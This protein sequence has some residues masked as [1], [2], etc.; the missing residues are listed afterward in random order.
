MCILLLLNVFLLISVLSDG[1]ES[2]RGASET[3]QAVKALLAE[4]GFTV[5]DGAVRVERAPVACTLTRDMA[6]E[7]HTVERLIGKCEPTDQGGNIYFYRGASGQAIL[8]GSGET[9]VLFSTGAVPLRGG[10]ERTAQRV[11]RRAGISAVPIGQPDTGEDTVGFYGTVNGIPVYNAALRLDFSGDGVYMITGVRLFDAVTEGSDEGLLDSVTVLLRF[12]EIV[13]EEGF[14]C[15][16]IDSVAPGYLQSVTRS[17]EATLSPVWRIET[18]TGAFLINAKTG[19]A[20]N[21]CHKT[22]IVVIK[23]WFGCKI[24]LQLPKTC[25]NIEVRSIQFPRKDRNGHVSFASDRR[26][27][28]RAKTWISI[29]S[30][31]GK[32]CTVR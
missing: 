19:K 17:G 4:D 28:R 12:V 21:R 2:R 25:G 31:A 5:G 18:D 15:S 8:R 10:M 16:R 23:L 27:Q 26:F 9:D 32:S 1:V 13:R 30:R 29:S 22:K 3:V 7:L 14:I 11:L 20:E 6:L 24:M